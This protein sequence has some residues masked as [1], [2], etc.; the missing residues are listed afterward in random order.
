MKWNWQKAAWPRFS[1]RSD[2]LTDLEGQFLRQSGFFLGTLKHI[3]R[4][5][6]TTLT[7]EFLS[8][9]ALKTSEI[10]GELLNRDSI[11]SSIRRHFGLEVKTRKVPSA[12]QGIADM[13]VSVY[14]TFK[15]PL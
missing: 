2:A 9:E 4:E 5:D 15:Q 12:E 11:Q 10:E 14:K 7:V 13:M 3:K 1:Y 6:R 8:T